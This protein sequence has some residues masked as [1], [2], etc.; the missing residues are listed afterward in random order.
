MALGQSHSE[1]VSLGA[2]MK[3]K[4]EEIQSKTKC[5][6]DIGLWGQYKGHHNEGTAVVF[7]LQLYLYLDSG[8]S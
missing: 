4:L 2:G 7:L 8:I 3:T 1:S 6:S 5:I